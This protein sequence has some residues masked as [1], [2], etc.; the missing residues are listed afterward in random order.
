[1]GSVIRAGIKEDDDMKQSHSM[2]TPLA[3]AR[4]LGSAKS[5][6]S[7][8]WHQRLTAI[9]MVPLMVAS[10]VVVALIGQADYDSALALMANPLVATLLLILVLVG[11]FH[12][13][14][15]LQVVIEDYVSKEGIRMSFIILVKMMMFALAALSVLSILKLAL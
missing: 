10:L 4:G 6:L 5:G 8:W 14:L 7:H 12:A 13:A 3:R 9:A 1:M 2:Q 11:F 15:G